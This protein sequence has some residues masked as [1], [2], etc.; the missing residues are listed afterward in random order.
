LQAHLAPD[1]TALNLRIISSTLQDKAMFGVLWTP[2]WQAVATEQVVTRGILER[3]RNGDDP[4]A[5]VG[6]KKRNKPWACSV[7]SR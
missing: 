1:G 5:F 7:R 6:G 3:I 4:K 2:S